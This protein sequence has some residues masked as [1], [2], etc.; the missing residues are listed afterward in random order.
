[1]DPQNLFG[2][3]DYGAIRGYF[4][5]AKVLPLVLTH[6]LV[7]SFKHIQY[8]CSNSVYDKCYYVIAQSLHRKDP[9][10][11]MNYELDFLREDLCLDA[12][13]YGACQDQIKEILIMRETLFN[14]YFPYALCASRMRNTLAFSR[15]SGNDFLE[16]VI[17]HANAS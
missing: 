12:L 4:E 9:V 1:M 17:I 16:Y 2:K 5:A 6:P 15:L 7:E 8:F 14:N 11:A 3:E 10:S 13:I